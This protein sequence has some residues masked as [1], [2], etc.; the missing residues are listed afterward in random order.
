MSI[1]L[2]MRRAAALGLI[3]AAG[4]AT[5]AVPALADSNADSFFLSIKPN[6]QLL[7]T[8]HAKEGVAFPEDGR[9]Y[10]Y[11]T[12][13]Y[14]KV[15]GRTVGRLPTI[16]G[17][18][19]GSRQHLRIAVKRSTR[20]KVRSAAKRR[21]TRRVVLTLVHRV[22]LTTNIPGDMSPRQETLTQQVPLR[23]ARG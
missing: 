13:G 22:T 11:S 23:I 4:A 10:N 3:A 18:A 2:T 17:H 8:L 7:P 15:G 14:L 5:Q 9:E 21:G 6:A 20:S 1:S 19:D 16:R 12:K